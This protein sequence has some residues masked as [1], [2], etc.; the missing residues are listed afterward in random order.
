MDVVKK[1]IDTIGGNISIESVK[2][3]GCKISIKIP[4]T[5]AI[6]DG[7]EVAAGRSRY[8]IPITAIRESF[9]PKENEVIADSEGNEMIMIRGQAYP[10]YRLHRL[11]NIRTDVTVL[12]H[13]IM[14]M[15]EDNTKSACLFVDSLIGEQQVVVKALP[16]YIKKAKGIAGCTILG[17]G[18]ISL[19]VD[20]SG[21]LDR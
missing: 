4:L 12:T 20:V 19:I 10:I 11:F 2:G 6:I 14:V 15:V 16:T 8:T 5:L 3:E 9:K 1:N 18:N 7:L 13:G 17:D 21:I